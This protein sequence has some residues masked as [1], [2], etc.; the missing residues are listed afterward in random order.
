L[1]ARALNEGVRVREHAVE[2]ALFGH[3][4]FEADCAATP[5]G[6]SAVLLTLHVRGGGL[7]AERGVDPAGLRSVVGLGR[8]LAHEI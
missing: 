6:D 4:A 3:P 5:L 1:I 2:I 8:M 7:G